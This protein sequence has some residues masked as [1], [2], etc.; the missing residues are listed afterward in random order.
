MIEGQMSIFDFISNDN[1]QDNAET[2]ISIDKEL[3]LIE[4]FAGY[5]SQ[6]YALKMLGV[7]FTH[8]FVCEFDKYACKSYSAIHNVDI[9]PI[10]IKTVK[11]SDLN[12]TDTDK[13][14][15]FMT[16]SFPCTDLSVAGKQLGMSRDSGTRSGLL[17]EV[18]RILKEL[19]A[20]G[21]E[22]P[23]LLMMENVPQVHGKKQ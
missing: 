10:D 13:Y 2:E 3:R 15:Y 19:V 23:Q 14:M 7:K 20:D 8:H 17:W 5:G 6:A 4:M 22:L 12:I 16:Y 18:E 9:T 1:V 11:G 21:K